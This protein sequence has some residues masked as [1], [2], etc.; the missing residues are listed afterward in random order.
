MLCLRD[1]CIRE[2]GCEDLLAALRG[3]PRG[4][5]TVDLSRNLV[6]ARGVAALEHVLDTITDLDLT[7]NRLGDAPVQAL[8]DAVSRRGRVLRRL[9]LRDNLIS[10]LAGAAI[11]G[12]LRSSTAL[13]ELMLGWNAIRGRGASMIGDAMAR[14][15]SVLPPAIYLFRLTF[16]YALTVTARLLSAYHAEGFAYSCAISIFR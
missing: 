8:M 2:K 5:H 16:P 6:G 3:K 15:D 14:N 10:G 4:V 9:V 11:A 12:C 1:N 13:E 7:A